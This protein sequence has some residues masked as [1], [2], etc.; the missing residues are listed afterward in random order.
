MQRM[1]YSVIASIHIQSEYYL[2]NRF[3]RT[4]KRAAEDNRFRFLFFKG[5]F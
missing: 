1:Q 5:A 2:N 3:Y 4:V